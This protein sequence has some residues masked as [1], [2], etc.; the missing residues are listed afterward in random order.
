LV[1]ARTAAV[2]ATLDLATITHLSSATQQCN[3]YGFSCESTAR[4]NAFFLC[5][6]IYCL[7]L[8]C[9][10]ALTRNKNHRI[11]IADENIATTRM[12]TELLHTG[13]NTKQ[14]RPVNG[15]RISNL[16]GSMEKRRYI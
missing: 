3:R 4:I 6:L 1:V 11:L 14:R 8:Y 13:E 9:H 2:L 12:Y 5:S 7:L 10:A 15:Q 16:G